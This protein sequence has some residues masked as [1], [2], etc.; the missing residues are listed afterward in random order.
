MR[1][2]P[3]RSGFVLHRGAWEEILVRAQRALRGDGSKRSILLAALKACGNARELETGTLIHGEIEPERGLDLCVANTLISMYAKCGRMGDAR[4]IF[5]GI[6]APDVISWNVLALGCAEND[7]EELAL[8]LLERMK[9]CGGDA[10]PNARTFLAAVK[11]CSSLAGK[12]QGTLVNGKLVKVRA[13]EKGSRVHSGAVMDAF[14]ANSLVDMYAK[15]GSMENSRQV[16]D[17]MPAHSVVSWTSVMLGYAE[18]GQG[19]SA[20]ELFQRIVELDD[21]FSSADASIFVAALKACTSLAA[22]ESARQIDGILVKTSAL[23]RGIFVHARASKSGWDRDICVASTLVNMYAKCG[24]M[25]NACMVF[26][27]MPRHDTVSWTAMMIGYGEHGDG[28]LVLKLFEQMQAQEKEAGTLIDGKVVKVQSVEK[29]MAMH[30]QAKRHACDSN[31]FV[32]NSMINM[33]VKCGSMLDARIVFDRMLQPTVVSW[34]ALMAGY[35][36]SG[37]LTLVLELFTGMQL[38]GFLPDALTYVYVLKACIGLAEGERSLQLDGRRIKVE[39][40]EK[41]MALHSRAAASGLDTDMFVAGS[42]IDLYTS[43][44]SMA[45]ARRVFDRLPLHDVVSWTALI[46][47]YAETGEGDVALELFRYMRDAGCS[48]DAQ[49]F[50][51][52][53]QTCGSSVALASVKAIHADKLKGGLEDDEFLETSLVDAYGKCG[54]AVEAQQLFD[55]LPRLD[56]PTWTSL[57]AGYS[58]QGDSKRVIEFFHAMQREGFQADEITFVCLLSACSHAGFVEK[59]KKYFELMLPRYRVRATLEHYVCMIDIYGRAN[60]L[61]AALEMLRNMPFEANAVAWRTLLAA[62]AKW[63]NVVV[64]KV[65]F[66]ALVELDQASAAAYSLMGNIY[67]STGIKT[68]STNWLSHKRQR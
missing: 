60:E 14:V 24:S 39:S 26:N 44:G 56:P 17:G 16:F 45:D 2:C 47:G 57:I 41:S 37:D 9:D 55:A 62:C 12:E 6:P 34:N 22:K 8:E 54:R 15:C 30:H 66:D 28:E 67:G 32:S 27:S 68:T 35:V 64:A 40:L 49:T 4:R 3:H 38:K 58:R 36:E 48:P 59:G 31:S 65:A 23:E 61:E 52:A 29:G 50:V 18:N 1:K 10:R 25:D 51:A 5:E 11:A 21:D 20:L 13:L 43:C 63:N 46:S 19:E 53:L 42:L 7:E 33:Y